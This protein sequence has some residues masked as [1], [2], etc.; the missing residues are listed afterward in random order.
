MVEIL[1]KVGR[2]ELSQKMIFEERPSRDEGMAIWM[3]GEEFS[4]QRE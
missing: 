2:E 3:S 1:E 4:R